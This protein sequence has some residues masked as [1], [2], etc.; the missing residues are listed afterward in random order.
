MLVLFHVLKKI[1]HIISS[2]WS[3]LGIHVSSGDLLTGGG[4][5]LALS[6]LYGLLRSVL[7]GYARARRGG[8]RS[9]YRAELAKDRAR[10]VVKQEVSE[11]KV[12]KHG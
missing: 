2:Q 4:G 9:N 5:I 6:V 10:A 7:W 8:Y 11:G 12:G 1:P 3:A